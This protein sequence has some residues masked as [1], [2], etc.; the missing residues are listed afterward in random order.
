MSN[1]VIAVLVDN[2]F[3]EQYFID[4]VKFKEYADAVKET[5]SDVKGMIVPY[6]TFQAF[7]VIQKYAGVFPDANTIIA[8]IQ[9]LEPGQQEKFYY[10][11][12]QINSM[13][14]A[15]EYF[16]YLV[17]NVLLLS[18]DPAFDPAF[19]DKDKTLSYAAYLKNQVLF[20]NE[21]IQMI[22]AKSA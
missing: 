10:E 17:S 9:K 5:G 19:A 7:L 4:D 18:A 20:L 11:L 3:D 21:L 12:N 22:D 2:E 16:N 6:T 8:E 13:A 1:D 14:F 15:S